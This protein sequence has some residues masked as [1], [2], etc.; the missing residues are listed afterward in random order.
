MIGKNTPQTPLKMCTTE[1]VFSCKF[2]P[3]SGKKQCFASPS[4]TSDQKS[5]YDP[6]IEADSSLGK[7]YN[8]FQNLH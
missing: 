3:Q 4:P 1:N 5:S 7:V 6:E 2:L 8:P